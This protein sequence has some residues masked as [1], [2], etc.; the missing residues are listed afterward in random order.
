MIGLGSDKQWKKRH[1]PLLQRED[2]TGS[3][4]CNQGLLRHREMGSWVQY[5]YSF[6]DETKNQAALKD[7]QFFKSSFCSVSGNIDKACSPASSWHSSPGLTAGAL[8]CECWACLARW[9]ERRRRGRRRRRW[10]WRAAWRSRVGNLPLSRA[11]RRAVAPLSGSRHMVATFVH[12]GAAPELALSATEI[13]KQEV[14][15]LPI[16]PL[17][18]DLLYS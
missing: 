6:Y 10:W 17:G 5:E 1:T 9:R 18:Q 16:K 3:F 8:N 7:S 2:C 15:R 12:S 4:R 11:A 13:W 14:P